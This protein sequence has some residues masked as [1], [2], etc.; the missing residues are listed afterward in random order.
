[1][2]KRIKNFIIGQSNISYRLSSIQE[3]LGRI[4]V[5]QTKNVK[6]YRDSEFKVF[7][8][9]GEDGIIQ[10]LINKLR[11]KNKIFIE[12][13]VENYTESNTRFL[14]QNDNWA[15]LIFDGSKENIDYI[16]KDPIYW[17]SNLKA[18]HLFITKKNINNAILSNGIKGDVGLLS[19]DIDGNDYW[20]WEEIECISPDIV[21][22]EYNSNFGTNSKITIPYTSTFDRNKAHFSKIYYGASI[23]ALNYLGE[24]KG[25]KLVAANSAG[26]N[27][28]FAKKEHTSLEKISI[29]KA[30]KISSFRE[31]HNENGELDYGNHQERAN[32]LKNLD[33]FD[34]SLNKIVKFSET[35]SFK[36]ISE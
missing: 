6:D 26:N 13:G 11:L 19:I 30:Y 12:F 3:A 8:Q 4:E 16:K 33:V 7:S 2:F 18:E 27:L 22:I 32:L 1:M 20:I 21:I 31:S 35:D 36:S 34:I 25:Y 24:K 28:F 5:R 10:F 29:D 9:W 15:G 14:L 23:A 17:A